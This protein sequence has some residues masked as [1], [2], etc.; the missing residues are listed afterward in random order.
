MILRRYTGTF[1]FTSTS[2]RCVHGIKL[3]IEA[4]S[5]AKLALLNRWCS[6]LF[7][8]PSHINRRAANS[9]P[10]LVVAYSA[11]SPEVLPQ[12]LCNDLPKICSIVFNM[13]S[14]RNKVGFPTGLPDEKKFNWKMGG[15][16]WNQWKNSVWKIDQK[17]LS[18]KEDHVRK[19]FDYT[20]KSRSEN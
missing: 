4:D 10:I 8:L 1:T 19:N 7:E 12:P 11:L 18:R 6:E 9:K 5:C 3:D 16:N 20:R 14:G 2:N 13:Q 17:I 15:K